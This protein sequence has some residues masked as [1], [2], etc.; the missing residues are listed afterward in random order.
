MA[1]PSQY[2][3]R[4]D[5]GCS[6]TRASRRCNCPHIHIGYEVAADDGIDSL[7]L[8][9]P[10]DLD[11]PARRQ[12]LS[13]LEHKP[14]LAPELLAHRCQQPRRREQHC[15]MTI[16]AARV[17]HSVRLRRELHATLLLERRRPVLL[18]MDTQ[19]LRSAGVACRS[20]PFVRRRVAGPVPSSPSKW[21]AGGTR[22]RGSR[23]RDERSVRSATA[24]TWN[25]AARSR[26]AG[27]V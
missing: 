1:T 25:L 3:H 15:G 14:Y 19:P 2:P 21:R 7:K 20:E 23:P 16:M 9:A 6:R 27:H 22:C 12:L 5:V 17:H 10:N 8:S 13:M 26:P 11:R 4:E 24:V 18:L